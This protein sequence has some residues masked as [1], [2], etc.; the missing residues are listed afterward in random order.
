MQIFRHSPDLVERGTQVLEP[1]VCVS[2][3]LPEVSA[4]HRI[5]RNTGYGGGGGENFI[6]KYYVQKFSEMIIFLFITLF[7][8]LRLGFTCLD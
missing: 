6:G 3:S 2:V 4:T 7:N 8:F 1:A 5:L